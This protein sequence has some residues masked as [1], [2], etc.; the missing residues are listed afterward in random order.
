[1]RQLI[2]LLLGLA[3][4]AVASAETYWIDWEG[5][6][7]T[8]GL[9][10]QF[11][12][13]RNWGN[14]HGQYQGDGANPTLENGILT[15]DSLYDAGVFDFYEMDRPGQI[16][17]PP[18]AALVV[19]WRLNVVQ[20]AGSDDPGIA[21]ASNTGRIVGLT[22]SATTLISEFEDG[23]VIPISPGFHDYRLTSGNMVSYKLYVDNLLKH[24]GAFWQ[25]ALD[26]FVAWGD[27]VQGAASLH[28]WDYFRF[29]ALQ[30]PQV[31]DVNCDGTVDLHDINPF[32][33]VLTDTQGYEQTYPGCWLENADINSDGSVNFGDINPFVALLTR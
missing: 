10:D 28:Q 5:E 20:V 27:C 24:E 18:G 11:G 14:W 30:L 26:S 7:A 32:V 16:D 13:E 29:G 8:N 1:M 2:G 31:G 12:W 21:V 33:Q 17:P 22:Y 23:V 15:F 6:G 25:G 4:C 19:E 3:V 9:P